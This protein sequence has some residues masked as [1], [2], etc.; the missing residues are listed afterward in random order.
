MCTRTFAVILKHE[1]SHVR[2]SLCDRPPAPEMSHVTSY[3]GR[4]FWFFWFGVEGMAGWG[5]GGG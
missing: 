2:L 5:G 3:F 1:I 4:N